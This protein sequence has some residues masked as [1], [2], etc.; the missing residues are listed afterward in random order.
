MAYARF[1]R[2][3]DIYV[4]Q[5]EG[6]LVCLSCQLG[7]EFE[8]RT[9]TRSAMI[10]HLEAHLKAGHKVPADAFEELRNEIAKEGDV[11]GK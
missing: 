2:S 6:D 7:P 3:S 11:V 1:S 5:E 9:L 8:I 10:R 4:Y